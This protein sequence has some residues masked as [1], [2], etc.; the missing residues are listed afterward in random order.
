MCTDTVQTPHRFLLEAIAQNIAN[1]WDRDGGTALG[2]LASSLLVDQHLRPETVPAFPSSQEACFVCSPAPDRSRWQANG[3]YP[4]VT[5][6]RPHVRSRSVLVIV[7]MP[8][9]VYEP[10]ES[11]P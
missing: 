8:A 3:P 6:A 4:D 7:G 2:G 5:C 11:S 1:I 10:E 9:A